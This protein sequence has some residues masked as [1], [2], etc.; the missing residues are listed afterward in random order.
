MQ[1]MLI[2]SSIIDN[3]KNLH[4]IRWSHK[5]NSFIIPDRNEF[6]RILLPIIYSHGN[7]RAFCRLLWYYNLHLKKPIINGSSPWRSWQS[8][9]FRESAI[10]IFS[11][12][13]RLDFH[14]LY[15]MSKK[16]DPRVLKPWTSVFSVRSVFL[17]RQRLQ[18]GWRLCRKR[19]VA[20]Q[21]GMQECPRVTH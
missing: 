1:P 17:Y 10:L 8:T 3:P 2:L 7:F 9:P 13:M 20:R 19:H 16:E 21:Q 15:Q 11:E 18:Y 12:T 5:G 6:A 14:V 4:L